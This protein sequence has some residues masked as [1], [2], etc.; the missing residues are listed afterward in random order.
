MASER[1]WSSVEKQ[2][3]L[4]KIG[5]NKLSKGCAD[6]FNV[7]ETKTRPQFQKECLTRK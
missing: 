4:A 1:P 3:T 2:A 7:N 6:Y 5:K